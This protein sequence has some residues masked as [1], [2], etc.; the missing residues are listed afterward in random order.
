MCK[1]FAEDGR[2]QEICFDTSSSVSL[3]DEQSRLGFFDQ[4]RQYSM[5]GG[6]RLR[7]GGIGSGDLFS[8]TRSV[9]CKRGQ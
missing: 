3:L 9:T 6:R 4:C 5:S 8:F 7:C 2:V 1:H